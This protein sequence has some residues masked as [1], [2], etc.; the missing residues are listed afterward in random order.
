MSHKQN[1]GQN[2]NIKHVKNWK[3]WKN[4]NIWECHWQISIACVIKLRVNWIQG[5]SSTQP[6][7]RLPICCLTI[8]DKTWHVDD[9]SP[10]HKPKQDVRKWF[11]IH[12]FENRNNVL[13][14]NAVASEMELCKSLST[15]QCDEFCYTSNTIPYILPFNISEFV[16]KIHIK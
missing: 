1:S 2:H 13:L 14:V 4:S 15:R 10:C 16:C 6:T 7:I 12:V 8:Q 9:T 3:L 5:M 11:R